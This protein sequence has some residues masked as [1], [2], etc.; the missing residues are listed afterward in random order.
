MINVAVLTAYWV[1]N[2]TD[3][4]YQD[5]FDNG[6]L[7]ISLVSTTLSFSFTV[8]LGESIICGLSKHNIYTKIRYKRTAKK[9]YK[10]KVLES[11]KSV[12]IV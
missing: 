3:P 12:H 11:N 2:N 10:N 9:K 5:T 7:T 8:M 1:S 4:S 6:L